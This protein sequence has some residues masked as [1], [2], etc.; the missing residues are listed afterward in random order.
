MTLTAEVRVSPGAGF[1]SDR[2][3]LR[4]VADRDHLLAVPCHHPLSEVAIQQLLPLVGAPI[5]GVGV[6]Q[7]LVT[8]IVRSD[9][10]RGCGKAH[11]GVNE[12]AG[13]GAGREPNGGTEG[14]LQQQA[15]AFELRRRL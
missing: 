7:G 5:A 4:R 8:G 6:P 2:V 15:P 3:G 10:L 1:G 11:T 13:A 12:V 14:I 9:Q